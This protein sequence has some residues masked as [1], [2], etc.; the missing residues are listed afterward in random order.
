MN[1]PHHFQRLTASTALALVVSF[2]SFAQGTGDYSDETNWDINRT[3]ERAS[4]MNAGGMVGDMAMP[5]YNPNA[6]RPAGDGLGHHQ[7]TQDVEMRGNSL[8]GVNE[9]TGVSRIVG[10]GVLVIE[11]LDYPIDGYDAANKA[12]VDEESIPPPRAV[13]LLSC[14]IVY[15]VSLWT[16]TKTPPAF[17]FCQSLIPA[18]AAVGLMTK[19]S[20]SLRKALATA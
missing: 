1:R 20:V 3:T 7:A 18:V 11:N 5:G 9:I 2:P 14:E 19:K 13:W 6:L 17:K 4:G 10:N 15:R 12:Y 16:H 8:T